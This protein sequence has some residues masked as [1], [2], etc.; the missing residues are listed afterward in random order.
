MTLNE[1][2]VSEWMASQLA[3]YPLLYSVVDEYVFFAC[4]GFWSDNPQGSSS[5]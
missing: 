1:R 2:E 5:N 4:S 3:R